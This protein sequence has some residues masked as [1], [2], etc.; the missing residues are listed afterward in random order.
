MTTNLFRK[1]AVCTDVHLGKSNNSTVHNE[2]CLNFIKWFIEQAELEDCDTA[3]ICGDWHHNRSSLNVSTLTYSMQCLELLNM[4]FPNIY[5]IVGNHDA[6]YRNRRDVN[7]VAWGKYL[8][9]IHLIDNIITLDDVTFCSWLVEN[10]HIGLRQIRSKYCF[11][12]F[13][14]GGFK[15][16]NSLIMPQHD[17]HI[18][19]DDLGG[20]EH[21]FS[22]HYHK[23]QSKIASSGTHIT[24][25]GNCFPHD[26][27]DVD[28]ESGR[29]MMVLGWGEEP[30]YLSWPNAP[31][32]RY[33][34]LSEVLNNTGVLLRPHMSCRVTVDIPISFEESNYIKEQLIPQ[35]TLREMQLI[36]QKSSELL[37]VDGSTLQFHSIDQI[38]GEALDSIESE[39][40]DRQL[41]IE[42]YRS[43]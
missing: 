6:Y 15:L 37:D 39:T 22:G 8:P 10:E 40:I 32:Y 35:Y 25:F 31:T 9:N 30:R 16:N 33:Y 41:L 26:Y 2:D 29:G 11:G 42:I 13:E 27:G 5:F 36:P 38:V 24:Y 21:V 17:G 34:T 18:A 4:A 23:R 19:L 1:A 12:H 14:L 20:F 43:L 7:S 28:E 3:I